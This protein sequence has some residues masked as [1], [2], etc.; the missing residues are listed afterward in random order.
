LLR[1]TAAIT[2]KI[3]CEQLAI[4]FGGEAPTLTELPDRLTTI[5]GVQAFD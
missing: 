3:L 5:L 1:L 4:G 2:L